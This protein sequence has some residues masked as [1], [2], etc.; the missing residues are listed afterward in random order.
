M[1]LTTLIYYNSVGPYYSVGNVL[2]VYREGKCIV[3]ELSIMP[4]CMELI[5]SNYKWFSEHAGPLFPEEWSAVDEQVRHS[6]PKEA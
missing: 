5:R 6:I 4:C 2:C 1:G 3:S